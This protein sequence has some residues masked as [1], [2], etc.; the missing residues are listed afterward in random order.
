[1]KKQ[2]GFLLFLLIMLTVIP[3]MSCQ[4]F[5]TDSPISTLKRDPSTLSNDQLVALGN[6]AL[7]ANDPITIEAVYNL[8]SADPP[9]AEED[10]EMLL[11]IANLGIANS[12]I[13]GIVESL[14]TDPESF[15]LD[16][17]LAGIDTGMIAT[18]ATQISEVQVAI[19]AGNVTGIAVSDSQL[20]LA[21]VGMVIAAVKSAGDLAA[22]SAGYDPGNPASPGYAEMQ[23]AEYLMTLTGGSG[24]LA[25]LV[26]TLG[27]TY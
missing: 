18:S 6:A 23:Q 12:G 1:M 21:A 8:L 19:D 7:E 16:A 5:F 11:L 22:F 9:S 2:S 3:V 27:V 4:D 25:A 15:D 17:L 10:P 26:A 20:E 24:D 13:N 14:L